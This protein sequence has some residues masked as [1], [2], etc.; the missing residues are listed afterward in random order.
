MVMVLGIVGVSLSGLGALTFASVC[1]LPFVVAGF[2]LGLLSWIMGGSD[3]SLMKKGRMDEE[4]RNPTQAGYICGIVA[5]SISAAILL[6][7]VLAVI[8]V[9]VLV[10][11]FRRH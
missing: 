7:I 9:A 2:V 4:G 10:S 8:G 11:S 3:L 1:F 6:L 5:T